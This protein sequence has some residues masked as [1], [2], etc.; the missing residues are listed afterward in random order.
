MPAPSMHDIN[1]ASAGI[2]SLAKRINNHEVQED[3][4][5]IDSYCP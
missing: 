3:I 1:D 5:Y 2:G 4:A